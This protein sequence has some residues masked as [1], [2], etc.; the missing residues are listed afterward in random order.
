MLRRPPRSTLFP[1]T[2]LF[3][4]GLLKQDWG[5]TGFVISDASAT[6]GS[7]V[8]HMTEPSTPVAAQHAWEAGLDVVFQSSYG[9]QRP[10]L[11]AMQ[12]GLV[13]PAIVDAAV[14]RVLRAKFE[15]GL[16]EKP[17][18]DVDEAARVNGS[19]DHL[20]LAREAAVKS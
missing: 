18:V 19:A 3:R 13:A 16:F 14:A 10:Y 5:F 2:T 8:L 7:T 11:D 6:G 4:S 15:L 1:Y 9:Q 20:A 17:Y 12:R